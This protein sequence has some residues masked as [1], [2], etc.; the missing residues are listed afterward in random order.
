M[1]VDHAGQQLAGPDDWLIETAL[2]FKSLL[3]YQLDVFALDL[4]PT[5]LED[6]GAW[7]RRD[8]PSISRVYYARGG[9]M[10][11]RQSCS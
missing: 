3:I 9:R 2:K 6:L 4:E 8:V 7:V 5:G 11:A 10:M 1:Q